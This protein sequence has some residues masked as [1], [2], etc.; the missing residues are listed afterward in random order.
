MSDEIKSKQMSNKINTEGCDGVLMELT[1]NQNKSLIVDLVHRHPNYNIKPFKDAFV[2][3][4]KKFSA[5]QNYVAIGY[6]DINYGISKV[7]QNIINYTNH[8]DN[9]DCTQF[10]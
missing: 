8:I 3:M 6:Y 9:I 2:N 4:I 1:L 7:S 5:N 10:D